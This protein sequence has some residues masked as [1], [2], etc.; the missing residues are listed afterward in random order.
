MVF[1]EKIPSSRELYQV[2]N[3]N[4]K[5]RPRISSANVYI[6]HS[7]V[8]CSSFM[9]IRAEFY[10]TLDK[11]WI[12]VAKRDIVSGEEYYIVHSL[13]GSLSFSLQR[14]EIP[15]VKHFLKTVKPS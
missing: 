12:I 5:R 9:D 6:I 11:V 15:R 8:G 2:I 3:V 10:L 1:S 14:R 4:S 7:D 13:H